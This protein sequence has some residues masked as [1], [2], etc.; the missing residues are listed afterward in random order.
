MGPLGLH[1]SKP[2]GTVG[3]GSLLP[4]AR[5]R[6]LCGLDGRSAGCG[7]QALTCAL[8]VHTSAVHAALRARFAAGERARSG[9]S[10]TH[11][12]HPRLHITKSKQASSSPQP[13]RLYLAQGVVLASVLEALLALALSLFLHRRRTPRPAR[14]Q[15]PPLFTLG[16]GGRTLA[17]CV[18]IAQVPLRSAFLRICTCALELMPPPSI[19]RTVCAP[20]SAR[21]RRMID[22]GMVDMQ[23]ATTLVKR[24]IPRR[25]P[26][27][28][29][30][31]VVA[32]WSMESP[33][34]YTRVPRRH[35][36]GR[37]EDRHTTRG[38]A[39]ATPSALAPSPRAVCV[40]PPANPQTSLRARLRSVAAPPT[41]SLRRARRGMAR[42]G[43]ANDTRVP[44]A[45]SSVRRRSLERPVQ[46]RECANTVQAAGRELKRQPSSTA[47]A[48]KRKS[49]LMPSVCH[50]SRVCD[51]APPPRPCGRCASPSHQ[52]SCLPPSSSFSSSLRSASSTPAPRLARHHARRRR[53]PPPAHCRAPYA[54]RLTLQRRGPALDA[55]PTYAEEIVEFHTEAE[56]YTAFGLRAQDR[57]GAH[58]VFSR[59]ARFRPRSE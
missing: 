16:R 54:A 7:T 25:T 42:L 37:R 48:R 21:T 59:E 57:G 31:A 55:V 20:A 13:R 14:R 35:L 17:R 15:R 4:A 24:D 51:H 32:R 27:R 52:A 36:A 5:T 23:R 39:S 3:A 46:T 49:N 10:S 38:N 2:G 12:V 47:G 22:E 28:G 1:Q 50:K 56:P 6:Y 44:L 19:P 43:C 9:A 26:P 33:S 45:G 41:T 18:C 11:T 34:S 40:T 58:A 8:C 29:V 53:P 30:P